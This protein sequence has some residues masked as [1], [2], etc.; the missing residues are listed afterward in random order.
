MRVTADLD[1][2]QGHRNCQVE[3]PMVFGF[4]E[5]ADTVVVLDATPDASLRTAVTDAVRYCPAMALVMED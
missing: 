5:G 3:A 1:L 4:D 2:C